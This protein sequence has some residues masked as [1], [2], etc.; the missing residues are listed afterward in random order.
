MKLPNLLL[1][2]LLFFS[3]N[4]SALSYLTNKEIPNIITFLPLPPKENS[5]EFTYDKLQYEWGK[6]IRQTNRGE[7]A[8]KDATHTAHYIAQI[9]SEIIQ[10]DISPKTTPHTYNLIKNILDTTSPTSKKAKSYYHRKRPFVYFQE[11]TPLP[12][13][14]ESYTHL[15]SYPSGHT[16]IGWT[17][18]LVVAHLLPSFKQEI[19]QRGYE[20]GQSRVIVGYHYQTDVDT[21]RLISGVL[22]ATLFQNKKFLKDFNSAKQELQNLTTPSPKP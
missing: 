10:I 21:S 20:Y 9:F 18:A 8:I 16:L 22:V 15:N 19:L 17:S 12:K 11:K 7:Q 3:S 1:L 13:L 2:A 4:A 14:E 5:K 6:S